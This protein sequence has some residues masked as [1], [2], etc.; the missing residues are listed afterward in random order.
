MSLLNAALAYRMFCRG[1]DR[2]SLP[3]SM[4]LTRFAVREIPQALGAL[5]PIADIKHVVPD[6]LVIGMACPVSS[7]ACCL[8]RW[9]HRSHMPWMTSS[10]M[11]DGSNQLGEWCGGVSV[12]CATSGYA[13]S[14]VPPGILPRIS[15]CTCQSGQPKLGRLFMAALCPH[16]GTKGA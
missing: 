14:A 10:G 3:L 8:A 2:L 1:L 5:Q 7:S 13:S 9:K 4:T 6:R 11:V 16:P 15:H 12:V